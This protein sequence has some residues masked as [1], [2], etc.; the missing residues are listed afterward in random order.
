MVGR[1]VGWLVG[2]LFGRWVT[3]WSLVA[4]FNLLLFQKLRSVCFVVFH[5]GE[6]RLMKCKLDFE[7]YTNGLGGVLK[8]ENSARPDAVCVESSA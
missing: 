6:R 5:V 2:W 8:G 7:S 3:V 1:F 4:Q